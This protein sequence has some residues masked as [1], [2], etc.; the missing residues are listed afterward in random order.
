M[1]K[2]KKAAK[3]AKRAKAAAPPKRLSPANFGKTLDPPVSRQAVQKAIAAG[4][5]KGSLTQ[6]DRGWWRIDPELGA[7]EWAEWTDH[8]KAEA[9]KGKAGGRPP[10][11]PRTGELFPTPEERAAAVAAKVTHAEA[12][13]DRIQVD[14]ELKRLDLEERRGR[15]VDRH[16]TQREAFQIARVVRDRILQIPDRIAA[17]LAAAKEPSDVHRRLLEELLA[18]LEALA[19]PDAMAAALLEFE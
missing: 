15:L 18:S 1:A 19:D 17:E 5:L 11:A 13:T 14:A 9:G 12:S 16:Q 10:G 8:A 7:T 6:T 2:R 4:R 3:K